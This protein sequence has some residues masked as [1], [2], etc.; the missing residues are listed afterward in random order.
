M[1]TLDI[2]KNCKF[3]HRLKYGFELGK[4][5]KESSCCIVLTRFSE[6]CADMDDYDSFVVEVTEN[7]RC[8]MFT[9]KA[10]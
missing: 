2:C 8:E 1:N 3:F 9:E 4:G 6:P 5:F 7:D 10:N